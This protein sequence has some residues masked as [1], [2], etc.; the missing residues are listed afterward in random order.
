MLVIILLFVSDKQ[1][2][3]K[4][5]YMVARLL[6]LKIPQNSQIPRFLI[7]DFDLLALPSITQ[8]DFLIEHSLLPVQAHA[9][10][11]ISSVFLASRC[12]N[13]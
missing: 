12:H 7:L 3:N 4:E 5:K 2:K 13:Y 11:L 1:L 6:T 9:S 10:W 8:Y